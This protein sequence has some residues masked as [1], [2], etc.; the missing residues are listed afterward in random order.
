MNDERKTKAQLIAELNE[1]RE[2]EERYRL[3]VEASHDLIAL[4]DQDTTPVWRNQA[5]EDVFGSD[6]SAYSDVL[7]AVH[8]DDHDHVTKAWQCLVQDGQ[9]IRNLRYRFRVPSGEYRHFESSAEA[10]SIGRRHLFYMSARDRTEQ[11]QAELEL[12]ETEQRLRTV[13]MA[14]GD[15]L[16]M[17]DSDHRIQLV[18]RAEP[19]LDEDD[20]LGMRLHELAV[21]EEQAQVKAHLDR[22]V[23]QGV[24]QEYQTVHFLPDGS[25]VHFSS[26][27]T[28]ILVAGHAN[29]SIVSSRDITE[30][31]QAE[32]ELR[33]SKAF[34]DSIIEQSPNSMWV[35]D[36]RGTMIRMNR[37]CEGLFHTKAEEVI[38]K[39]NIFEDDVVE[40]QGHMPAVREVF[41][42]GTTARFAIRY[43]TSRLKSISLERTVSLVLDVTVFAIKD[44]NGNVTNAVI[45]HNDVTAWEQALDKLR[46]SEARYR[47]FVQNFHGIAFR[48]YMSFVPGFFHGSVEPIT[49]YTENEFL[50]GRPSWDE[51]I[52]PDDLA[53]YL[54]QV[55]GSLHTVP[56]YST[57]REYRI[58]RK[59]GAV[60]WVHETIQN[61]CDDSGKPVL[62]QGAIHD[63]TERK[64]VEEALLKSE[65]KFR[66]I[67]GDS[68]A[69]IYVFD[70]DKN[71]TDSNAAGVSLLGYSKEELLTMS[72]PDVDADTQAV[73]PAHEQLLS[74]ELLTLYE[75]QLRRRDGEIVTVLNNSKPLT[76]SRGKVTGMLSTLVDITERKR[77]EGNLC[78]TEKMES[79]GQLAGGVA[80]DFNNQLSGIMNYADLLLRKT[81]DE[82]LHRYTEAIIRACTRGKDLTGQ[83]LAFSRKGKYQVVPV[84]IHETISEVISIL[85]HTIDRRVSIRQ[86]LEAN[87]PTTTGDPT[88]L[89]NALLNLGLNARDAMPVGGELVFA[90][91]TVTLDEEHCRK[92]SF[93]LVPGEYLRIRVTDSGTGMDDETRSKIF[94]PFFTTK[95]QD[96]GT[97]MGLA[98]AFGAVANHHGAIEVDSEVGKGTIMTVYLP[99]SQQ[100]AQEAVGAGTREQE[101]QE[102]VGAGTREQAPGTARILMVDDEKIVRE[103]TA[104]LLRDEGCKVVTAENGVEAVEYY[105]KS[106]QH[107]DLVILDMNMPVMNGRDAF[108]AMREINPDI[109]AVLATGYSLGN[110]VQEILDMGGLFH[111]QKPF[112][113]H[114]IILQIEEVL[115]G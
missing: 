4:A 65:E 26:V 3:L 27:A 35:S 58:V 92:S 98:S 104:L 73:L 60:R 14:S 22:V 102:A 16:L 114:D 51:V 18:N 115:G 15:Y 52:H 113:I 107:I 10:V 46:D 49:G 11:E 94:E 33:G 71:F 20:L 32:R 77:L 61:I 103:G 69:A 17:L 105:R 83:L 78:Q 67:F 44:T 70:A 28:P 30:R 50:A 41:E 82:E 19:G 111:I 24:S 13:F 91:D 36:T 7:P 37:A 1:L 6:I 25:E 59:D 29:G 96:K 5:W 85:A 21:P 31:K 34:L 89:Q 45:Q 9:P 72:I 55:A 57:Q 93:K 63:I 74:G 62:V 86:L 108:V 66:G 99:L 79:I 110:D 53:D 54:S 76:D 101:A 81:D 43:D 109:K 42:N 48:S 97:G 100:E 106:W 8:P 39:Y 84:N 88:Q 90:T 40:E 56:D 23:R 95:E 47:S 112:H 12:R 87:P 80:H 2:S 75:H 64:Q 68:V 38:G